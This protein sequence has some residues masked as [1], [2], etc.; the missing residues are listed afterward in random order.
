MDF[1]TDW[2]ARVHTALGN[3]VKGEFNPLTGGV[4]YI[5]VFIFY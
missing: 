4:A 1:N 2:T 5:R 3:A